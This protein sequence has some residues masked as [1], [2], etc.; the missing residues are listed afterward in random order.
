MT[1]AAAVGRCMDCGRP[2]PA[3]HS[4]LRARCKRCRNK[5]EAAR[6]RER[7]KVGEPRYAEAV[8]PYCKQ[9]YSY[10]TTAQ[11]GRETCGSPKCRVAR[12][13]ETKRAKAGSALI[14][15]RCS[16]CGRMFPTTSGGIKVTCGDPECQRMRRKKV[17]SAR[18]RQKPEDRTPKMFTCQRCGNQ[19]LG[20]EGQR[21]RYCPGG[22]KGLEAT[23]T[24][25][26]DPWSAGVL[27]GLPVGVA[28]WNDAA[29]TPFM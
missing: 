17:A 23:D 11:R 27:T 4:P 9:A 29:M 13:A 25:F 5:A 12:R 2:F 14:E 26:S 10:L 3:G 24:S 15:A 6:K 7:R 21:R 16:E 8:C 28:S 20:W 1:Q 22:C 19:I 18:E